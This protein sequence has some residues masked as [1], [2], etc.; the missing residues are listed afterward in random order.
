MPANSG[1]TGPNTTTIYMNMDIYDYVY[2]YAY[3]HINGYM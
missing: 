3:V 1:L 2:V